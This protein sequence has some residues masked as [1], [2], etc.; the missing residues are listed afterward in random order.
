MKRG[1]RGE[2]N[3]YVRLPLN[4]NGEVAS[5]ARTCLYSET[6]NYRFTSNN[7]TWRRS[8]QSFGSVTMRGHPRAH[9]S[10]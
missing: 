4:R 3:G 9:G 1:Q 6:P 8:S 5:E 10:I 2:S 7:L